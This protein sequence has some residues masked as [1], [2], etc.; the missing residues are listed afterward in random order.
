MVFTVGMYSSDSA[1]TAVSTLSSYM[2]SATFAADLVATGGGVAFA[3]GS[4]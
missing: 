1:D 3:V 2:S 4:V